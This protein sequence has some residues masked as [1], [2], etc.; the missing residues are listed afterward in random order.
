MKA[1][2][3]RGE[4]FHDRARKDNTLGR[5]QTRQELWGEEHLKRPP[6]VAL[7]KALRYLENPC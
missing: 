4:D 7:D 5:S 2:K 6:I 1:A 3:D